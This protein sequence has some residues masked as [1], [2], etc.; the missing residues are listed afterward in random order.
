MDKKYIESE[1]NSTGWMPTILFLV[2]GKT[3]DFV[4]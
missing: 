3:K 4:T 1:N 2:Q